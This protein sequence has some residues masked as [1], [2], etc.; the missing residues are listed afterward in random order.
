M[1]INN[2]IYEKWVVK[3]RRLGGL[4]CGKRKCKGRVV[5]VLKY[6]PCLRYMKEITLQNKCQN[7]SA[8]KIGTI[9]TSCG[10][11]NAKQSMV[12]SRKNASCR[13][14]CKC[15]KSSWSSMGSKISG[16]S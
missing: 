2:I 3:S 13:V 12:H 15:S 4:Q 11:S 5:N 9:Q 10:S 14:N 6:S 7:C 16:L 8:G 1:V